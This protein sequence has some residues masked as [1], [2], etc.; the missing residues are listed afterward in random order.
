MYTNIAAVIK[1]K[2]KLVN[3]KIFEEVLSLITGIHIEK[4]QT[5]IKEF[6]D[7]KSESFNENYEGSKKTLFIYF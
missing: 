7:W 3:W 5:E 2:N 1:K 6:K 4:T